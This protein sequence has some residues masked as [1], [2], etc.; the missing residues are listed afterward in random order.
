MIV[1]QILGVL[2]LIVILIVAY[3]GGRFFWRIKKGM[4]FSSGPFAQVITALPPINFC[5]ERS[6]KKEWENQTRINEDSQLLLKLGFIDEGMYETYMGNVTG[7]LS[8]W[9]HPSKHINVAV[10]EV[11]SHDDTGIDPIYFAD[12]VVA[13]NGGVFTLTNNP[14]PHNLP[15]P[16]GMPMKVVN[17]DNLKVLL[18][19]VG[20]NYPKNRKVKPV[21]SFK[22]FYVEQSQQYNKWV[23]QEEQLKSPEL[24]ALF[25]PLN[26]KFE[27]EL[28]T[29]LL[30]YA[31]SEE[32]ELL[33]ETVL[34]K[35][36]QQPSLS[37]E[38]WEEIRDSL[39]VVHEK[40][41]ASDIMHVMYR[42]YGYDK[43]EIIEDEL[44]EFSE[45]SDGINP[46]ESLESWA[47]KAKLTLP[48]PFATLKTPEIVCVYLGVGD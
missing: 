4:D 28:L 42:I 10:A 12:I 2:F 33:E 7:L 1:F 27:G 47:K 34:K 25:A 35:L 38:K 8:L 13:F 41:T 31:R 36:S 11:H 15:R 21:S 17:S 30:D 43:V 19:Q 9:H 14:Q 26:I 23:W 37:A 6:S 32:S 16:E 18:S 39:V 5:L 22:D 48:K 40:M 44:E 45:T 46:F 24:E 29:E 3:F 20:K